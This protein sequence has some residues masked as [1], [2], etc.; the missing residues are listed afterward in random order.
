MIHRK[1]KSLALRHLLA[2]V[3]VSV[4]FT[5]GALLHQAL[6]QYNQGVRERDKVLRVVSESYLPSISAALFYFDDNQLRLLADG[7]L[8]LPY[9]DSVEIVEYRSDEDKTILSLGTIRDGNND[10][11]EYSLIY[12]YYGEH[13]AIGAL[14]VT[15]SMNQARQQL[16]EQVRV[17]FVA[18]LLEIFGFAVVVLFIAQRMIFRHLRIISGFVLNIDTANINRHKLKLP[19]P[20]SAFRGSDE[21]DEITDA[22]NKMQENLALQLDEKETLIS[23]LY[24]RTFNN[25]QVIQSLLTCRLTD[26]PDLSLKDFVEDVNKQIKSMSLAHKE[27]Y[28]AGHLSRINLEEYLKSLTKLALDHHPLQTNDLSISFDLQ[29]VLILLDSAIP[30]GIVVNELLTDLLNHIVVDD[31]PENERG[32]LN[33]ASSIIESNEIEIRISDN[34]IYSSADPVVSTLAIALVEQQLGG[35]IVF[36]KK[37]GTTI[38]IRFRDNLYKE[39]VQ[40]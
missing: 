8:L 38:I 17:I 31:N 14:H 34:G 10:P 33:I 12:D 2:I 22:I 40:I 37:N 35:S 7:I 9:V 6:T 21:L 19:R 28:R 3:I 23:E 16:A 29:P 36:D 25:M 20:E 11:H 39:R 13:R 27:L 15:T 32:E 26:H 1:I 24:H 30:I 4:I 18:N 5:I